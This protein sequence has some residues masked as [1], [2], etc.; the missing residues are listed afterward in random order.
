MPNQLHPRDSADLLR[1]LGGEYVTSLC[2]GRVMVIGTKLDGSA[3]CAMARVNGVLYVLVDFDKPA[4]LAHA[5]AMLRGEL[6]DEGDS[7]PFEPVEILA[8]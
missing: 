2:D 3:V 5:R 6:G 1:F 4:A 7:F 8:R